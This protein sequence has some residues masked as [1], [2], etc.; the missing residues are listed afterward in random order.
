MMATPAFAQDTGQVDPTTQNSPTAK[1]GAVAATD[2]AQTPVDS[3]DIIVTATRR[4]EALSDVPL[5][6]S[7]VTA[8][9]LRNSG[10]SD[11]RGLTQVS[12]SLLVSSTSS[13]A[14]AGGARIRG[15]GTVGDNPGL[16]SSVAVFIDGVYR[17]RI[18]VGLTELGPVDRIEV[19]RGPQGTLFGRNASA[20]LISIITAKPKFATEASGELTVGNYNLRR[21]VLSL[22]TA[23]SET[24]AA[25]VDG[26]YVKRDGFVRDV[27]SG[28]DVN[29]RDRY[30]V[31][32]Q[33][34]FQPSSDLSFRLIGDYSNRNEE[35]C[36]APYLPAHDTVNTGGVVSFQPSTVAALE[37][38]LGG[39]I[40]D[41]TFARRVSITPGRDYRSDVKDY[42]L[43]GE[44]NFKIGGA[45]LTSITAYRYNKF[46]RGQDADYNNL[47]IVYRPGDGSVYNRFKTF[48]QELRLQGTTL[49]DKLD[50]LVG[51]YYANEQ[52]KLQDNLRY[53]ADYGRYGNCLLV[54]SI[55][56]V[57]Q[58][59]PTGNCINST[60]LNGTQATAQ[61]Q[62][63]AVNAGI[64]SVNA[65]IAALSAIPTPTPAQS[66]QLAALQAQLL[67]LQ[68]QQAAL[69]SALQ[70]LGAI[71]A[72]P[73]NPGFSSIATLL[74]QPTFNFNGVGAFDIYNQKST[75]FAVFTHNIFSITDR[76]K[77]TIGLRYTRERKHLDVNLTDNN[78]LCRAITGSPLQGFA[79]IPCVNPSVPGGSFVS[80]ETKSEGRVS[81]TGVLSWKMTPETLVYASYS[82]G[83]KAGG[84]NLDRTALTRLVSGGAVGGV[85]SAATLR[86]LEFEPETNNAI[87]LGLKYNG[88]GLDINVAAF[89]QKFKNFQL[90]TFNGIN[91]QVE[92]VNACATDLGG[93]DVDNN[94]ATGACTGKLKPGVTSTGLEAEVFTR[95]M[96]DVTFNLGATYVVTKY[97]RN[98][99]GANGRPLSNSLFQLPNRNLSNSNEFTGTASLGWT[100][101]IGDSGLRALF[102]VDARHM[103]SFNTGSDLDLEK[104]QRGFNTVNGRVGLRGP[105]DMW[106]I[107]FWGQNLFKKNYYQVGFDAFLQPGGSNTYRSVEQGSARGFSDRSSTLY[108]AF[109]GE[110]RTYGLTLRAKFAPGPR[111]E[112]PYVA[113]PAPPAPPATQTCADGSVIELNAACPVMAPPPPPPPPPAPSQGERG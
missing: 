39:S 107:E 69:I 85:T 11:I 89:Q 44:L 98:L 63:T 1:S 30:V 4:N 94:P 15:V 84:F 92:N 35:C 53:G 5:A 40:Q 70:R 59:T 91:F 74:G 3:G 102:Y 28:R 21:G 57:Q 13:E 66:A 83:Y 10:A 58:P 96:R 37:R 113:P 95:P 48:T 2:V 78:T 72:N 36:A 87:E 56:N 106:S 32:G 14:G 79:T 6:V 105:R 55:A 23:L 46:I 71:N 12:P 17:S 29:N 77:A 104:V 97:A 27:I 25:R 65:G 50:W 24:I 82:R 90:N 110:P 33:L 22:N 43:S 108:A 76:L 42:G 7:A 61:S 67:T 52:L 19:L 100:P 54:A 62:L 49:N 112:V 80:S 18:G 103:S 41:D 16:E 111:T 34:L 68:G 64:A 86:D 99:V 73:L 51:G 88:R 93:A 45:Q 75:N 47:D 20:G 109:L 101:A 9:T 31:R 8:E 26:V 38:G 60:V 81:G